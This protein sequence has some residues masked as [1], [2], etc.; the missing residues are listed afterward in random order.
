[1]PRRAASPT[2]Q[3]H[4]IGA[5]QERD[6]ERRRVTD[7]EARVHLPHSP[8]HPVSENLGRAVAFYS[9]LGFTETFRLPTEGEP[10]HVDLT[11]EG[12][13]ISIA[14]VASTR[15]DP[16]P[17]WPASGR[18]SL[19]RRHC[20][21]LREVHRERSPWTARP[22]ARLSPREQTAG[23][24]KGRTSPGATEDGKKRLTQAV[25][26]P[27]SGGGGIRTHGAPYEAQ[28]FSR[29]P[30]STAPAPRRVAH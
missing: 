5:R 18:H 15:D 7:L 2:C 29:P 19:D 13:K 11:L 10:I 22:D 21:G 8:D 28:R 26:G 20:R 9:S 27:A 1:M 14:S 6:L 3:R 30:R 12:Y 23:D 17:K 25:F 4:R 16:A 24:G